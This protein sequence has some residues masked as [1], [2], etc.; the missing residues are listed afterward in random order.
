MAVQKEHVITRTPFKKQA[1]II[2]TVLSSNSIINDDE[3][4]SL[5]E[6]VGVLT[7]MNELQKHWAD[8]GEGIPDNI[9]KHLF[10]NRAPQKTVAQKSE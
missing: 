10:E 1:S 3:R 5:N 8:G 2:S 7:W 4:A 9:K 6:T